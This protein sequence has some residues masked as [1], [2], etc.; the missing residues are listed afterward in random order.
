MGREGL[1]AGAAVYVAA[2]AA[3]TVAWG[4][5]PRLDLAVSGLFYRTG[6]GFFLSGQPWARFVSAAV[7]WLAWTVGLGILAAG[8]WAWLRPGGSRRMRRVTAYLTL[9]LLLGPG[10]LTNLLLKD[11]WGRARPYQVAAF[12]GGRAFTTP[13][14]PADQCTSN[15]SFVAG[16]PSVAFFLVAFA[17]LV[18][19]PG[20][21]RLAIAGAVAA[22]LAVGFVRVVQGQHFAS[23]VLYSGL[24]NVGLIWVLWRWLVAA[25]ERESS[26]A[27]PDAP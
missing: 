2:F 12:G 14:L 8:L 15:C 11:H 7:P 21:R 20:R 17:F 23:D 4:L 22:G 13:L 9:A 25:G 3:V 6:D 10:L 19:D 26:T 1:S 27:S 18:R 16:H 24:L 5:D